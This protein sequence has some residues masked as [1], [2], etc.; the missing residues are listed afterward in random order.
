MTTENK[1]LLRE[2]VTEQEWDDYYRIR[3]EVLRKP[4]NQPFSSTKDEAEDISF[5]LLLTDP[6]GRPAGAG[7]LQFNSASQGQIRSMAVREDLRGTGWGS[8][9]LKRLEQEAADRGMT[10]IVLDARIGA[11]HFYENA[12]YT[13]TGDSYLLFGE[14]PHKAMRKRL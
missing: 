13:V 1:F 11:V 4:W 3:Y 6:E 12:G 9:I 14:I 7:R 8:T 5:H 10:E 2:P